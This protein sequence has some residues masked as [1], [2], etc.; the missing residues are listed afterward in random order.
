MRLEMSGWSIAIPSGW[1]AVVTG[2]P[3]SLRLFLDADVRN[4]ESTASVTSCGIELSVRQTT[5]GHADGVIRW[6]VAQGEPEVS[7]RRLGGKDVRALAWTDGVQN[8]E[9]MFFETPAGV[10]L[11]ADL[12]T[13]AFESEVAAR[14]RLEADRVLDSFTWR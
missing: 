13:P 5:Q 6:H 2:E 9:T 7:M 12:V 14:G 1:T 10:L 3:A 8:I 11:R 4:E